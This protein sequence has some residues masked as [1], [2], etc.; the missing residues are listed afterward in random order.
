MTDTGSGLAG[1][2][3]AETARL[4]RRASIASVAVAAGLIAIKTAGYGATDSVSVLSSLLDSLLDLAASALNLFA[5]RQALAPADREHRFGHG[6]AEPLAG[7]GQAAF[8]AGSGVL[9]LVEAG[10]RLIVPQPV[11]NLGLG[12]AVILA[13]MAATLCL[14]A[15]QRHVIRRTGSM[16]IDADSLHYR[17]DLLV[18]GSVIVSLAL[19]GALQTA[20]LD[21]LFAIAIAGYILW[22]AWRIVALALTHLMD[23]ELPDEDR[24]RIRAIARAH[25]PVRAVHELRTRAAGPQ[26]FIQFHLELDGD[27]TLRRA[28]DISDAVEADIV[29][30]FPSAE[31][32]IHQDPDDDRPAG[33]PGRAIGPSRSENAN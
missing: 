3:P 20:Y 30:A 5:I 32:I 28:H 24:D 13:S 31:V 18:N 17:G 1:R 19:S 4:L 11:T 21:P 9:L 22:N 16:A 15:Y 26:T 29:R 14:V 27:I 33:P 25:P 2:E 12:V 7:L 8:V 10:R 23:R 6:K